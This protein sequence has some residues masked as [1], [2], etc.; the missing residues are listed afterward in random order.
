LKI[1]FA[2][3]VYDNYIDI[4][5]NVLLRS[6]KQSGNIPRLVDEGHEIRYYIYTRNDH[7]VQRVRKTEID[8]VQIEVFDFDEINNH[9]LLQK[10]IEQSIGQN[11]K[12]L[13]MSPDY[14][15]GNG[16]IY[17]I[18]KYTSNDNMC[19]SALHMRVDYDK[20]LGIMNTTDKEISNPELVTLAMENLHK[21]WG[22]AFI[23]V[24]SNNAYYSGSSIQPI[25]DKLWSV[26]FRIP[27]V[28]LAKF[29]PDDLRELSQFDHWD[30]EWPSFLIE[31][32][33]YK[34]IGSSDMFFAVELTKVRENIP[35]IKHDGQWN[36]EFRVCKKHG[37]INK[38]FLS[39]LR[40]E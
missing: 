28:F 31:N 18:C 36:D 25:A 21:S 37:E 13:F 19:I 17:N 38:N 24:P 33:R 5:E 34:Y 16:S 20:F 40:G 3:I 15:I 10:I 4:F 2:T 12:L 29:E 1:L 35:A 30:W 9:E 6:L 14:F 11:A 27:T 32:S 8:G 7:N 26:C 23:D 22:E 39:I